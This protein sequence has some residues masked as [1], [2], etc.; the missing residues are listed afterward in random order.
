ML[1]LFDSGQN[2]S[3][4]REHAVAAHEA[5]LSALALSF[6]G[7]RLGTCSEKGTLVRIFCT[8]TGQTLQ[9][10]RRG[11]SQAGVFSLAFNVDAECICSVSSAGTLHVWSLAAPAPD[12][13]AEVDQKYRVIVPPKDN[14]MAATIGRTMEVQHDNK[15]GNSECPPNSTSVLS[16]MKDLLPNYFSSEWSF[17]QFRGASGPAICAFGSRP[18]TIVVA[19]E[20][21]NFYQ[22]VYPEDGG[23]C[24]LEETHFFGHRR[25]MDYHQ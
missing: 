17:A 21:L 8:Q 24:E 6:D 9:E 22:C 12:P 16:F 20:D 4:A 14:K 25:S 10:L 2:G 23:E 13:L 19:G 1:Q 3:A 11:I 18:R 7:S 15:S 5:P